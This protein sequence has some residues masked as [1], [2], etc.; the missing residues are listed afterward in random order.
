MFIRLNPSSHTK[1]GS[2]KGNGTDS[3]KKAFAHKVQ[4][5]L[6]LKSNVDFNN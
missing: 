4:R 1:H 3:K 6:V 2:G 5:L